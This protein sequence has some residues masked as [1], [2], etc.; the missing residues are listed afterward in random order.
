MK[1][2]VAIGREETAD[3]SQEFMHAALVINLPNYA[4]ALVTTQE[5][6]DALLGDRQ[7]AQSSSAMA[8][9]MDETPNST[10]SR[11]INRRSRAGPLAISSSR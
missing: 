4:S 2:V 9:L 6:T 8:L 3:Y 11:A 1:R 5:V 7:L 10:H